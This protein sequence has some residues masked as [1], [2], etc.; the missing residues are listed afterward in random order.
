MLVDDEASVLKAL[1]RVLRETGAELVKFTEPKQALDE[2]KNEKVSVI[3]SD[4]R[5]PVMTGVEF[6]KASRQTNPDAIRILLTGYADIEA[7]A[8]AIN[9]G[10]IKYYLNKPWDNNLLVSRVNE[11]LEYY[12]MKREN[13]RLTSVITSRNKELKQINQQLAHKVKEQTEQLRRR[14]EGLQ[15]SFMQT[16]RALAALT[17][18]RHEEMGSH[19]QR[20]AYLTQKLLE[21]MELGDHDKQA[22]L[23]AAFL[24]DVGKVALPDSVLSATGELSSKNFER[25]RSHP[26]LGQSCIYGIDGLED[27][28]LMIRHHH[29]NWD[30]TGYPDNLTESAIPLGARMIRMADAFDHDAFDKGYPGLNQ[31]NDAAANLVRKSGTMFDPDLVRRFIDLDLPRQLHHGDVTDVIAIK[32]ADL[33]EGM[34]VLEDIH[35]KNG[36][37]LLPKGARLSRGMIGRV[38]KIDRV[39]PIP[40]A[41]KVSRGDEQDEE[42]SE[43]RLS[44]SIDVLV[45]AGQGGI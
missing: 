23:I 6:L 38:Q 1:S 25:L 18:M 8:G 22:I 13:V 29:E 26:L 36:L 39:D 12:R 42:D 27:V 33:E 5:M 17:E 2:L 19:S 4:Q 43:E 30:G 14:H 10:H 45:T 21:K 40:R 15:R 41:I 32:P 44:F 35:T 37:F 11:S 7:V 3:I 28:G 9:D 20:V 31:L 24:H 16:I 34:I